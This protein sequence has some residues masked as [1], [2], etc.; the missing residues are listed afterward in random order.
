MDHSGNFA[1]K[2]KKV[3]GLEQITTDST[4]FLSYTFAS[5]YKKM[6]L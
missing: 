6:C 3:I 2:K 4:C 5:V 1:K